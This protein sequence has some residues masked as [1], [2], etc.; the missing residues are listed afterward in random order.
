LI[1]E[2]KSDSRLP[3][4]LMTWSWTYQS[5]GPFIHVKENSWFYSAHL[6]TKEMPPFWCRRGAHFQIMNMDLI[7]LQNC[8]F[9]R[10]GAYIE[11]DFG[12]QTGIS[13][14]EYGSNSS[15][16]YPFPA[17]EGAYNEHL[18]FRTANES[19]CWQWITR[20]MEHT[21]RSGTRISADLFQL[22]VT[23]LN[24]VGVAE[25]HLSKSISKFL[26]RFW[27]ITMRTGMCHATT[28]QDWKLVWKIF[29]YSRGEVAH[30]TGWLLELFPVPKPATDKN[31]ITDYRLRRW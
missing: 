6:F 20:I 22:T 13:D 15:Q 3:W 7:H 25:Y 2:S 23:L 8:R 5:C 31:D 24:G 30:E 1:I 21:A 29:E 26:S 9:R 4:C 10:E 18:W 11:H 14:Y 16:N 27:D 17:R 12:P 19:A 28:Q